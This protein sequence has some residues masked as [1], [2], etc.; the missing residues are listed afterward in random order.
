MGL[1]TTDG[2]E[3]LIHIGIDTVK[4]DKKAFETYVEEGDKVQA[5]D[6]IL[7]FDLEFIKIMH[8]L[9]HHHAYALH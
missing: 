6:K 7:S 5:G 2:L 3:L 4:L 1:T 8:H 9:L